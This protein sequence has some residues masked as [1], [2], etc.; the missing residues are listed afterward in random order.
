MAIVTDLNHVD[1]GG[2]HRGRRR[3]SVGEVRSVREQLAGVYIEGAAESQ[4]VSGP[5]K[6]PAMHVVTEVRLTE[7][8]SIAQRSRDMMDDYGGRPS[9]ARD[10][11]SQARREVGF[12]IRQRVDGRTDIPSQSRVVKCQISNPQVYH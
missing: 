1:P 10:G 4:E 11:R 3:R 9:L 7:L 2:R 8:V 6:S 5:G 12:E